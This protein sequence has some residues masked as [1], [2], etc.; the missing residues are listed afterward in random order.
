M[1]H[2]EIQNEQLYSNSQIIHVD[3]PAKQDQFKFL[4]TH[5]QTPTPNGSFVVY[6]DAKAF[7]FCAFGE[8]CEYSIKN[9]NVL[10]Y[11]IA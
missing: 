2:F 4:H 1:N 5:T 6:C 7:C 11:V 3:A 8:I 9:V 10:I